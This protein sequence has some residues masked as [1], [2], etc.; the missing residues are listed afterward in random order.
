M[1]QFDL[2]LSTRPFKPYR[3]VNLGLFVLLLVLL[4][5]SAAQVLSYQQYSSLASASREEEMKVR[6]DTDLLTAQ[7][8]KLNAQMT[9]GNATAKLSEVELLNRLLVR[10]SF[11][12][13]RVFA[14]LERMM[15]EDVRL[16]SLIPFVDEQGRIGLTMEVRGRSLED[17][18]TFLK[19]LEDSDIFTDVAL[20]VQEKKDQN[21]SASGEVQFTLSSFY[22]PEEK[23]LPEK[24]D[25]KAQDKV[26]PKAQGK[27]PTKVVAK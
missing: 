16:M 3:A 14:N 5:V 6:A 24:V 11:S 13:T 21:L 25:P 10:K 15:P 12:W 26:E 20:A 27:A 8:Q 1:G 19:I 4:A 23:K 22:V 2:N 7:V 18:N 17:A 9:S